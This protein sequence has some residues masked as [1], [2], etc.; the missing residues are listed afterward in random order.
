MSGK[1]ASP[2]DV[3]VVGA[4]MYVCGKGTDGFGTI[5]PALFEAHRQGLVDRIHIAATSRTSAENAQCKAEALMEYMGVRPR[6]LVYPSAVNVDEEAYRLPMA[7]PEVRAAI[8]SVPDRLHF[9]ITRELIGQGLHVQVV[10]P[11]VATVKEVRELVDLAA[12]HQIYGCVEYHKRFDEANLKLLDLIRCGEL[13]RLLNFTIN[14]SQRKVIPTKMF[15]G[16]VESTDIF[17]YLG[18][19][20]VDL[21]YFLT[22]A[23]P[24]RVMSVGLKKYLADQGIDNYDTIHTLVEWRSADGDIFLSSHFTGW[25]DPDTTS[26]MSD[27]RL[28]VVGTNGRYQSDQKHRG[29]TLVTDRGGVEA[30]N[31]YF[32]QFYPGLD[33]DGMTAAGYGPK[34]IVQFLRDVGD[35]LAGRRN[36]ASLAGLRATFASSLVAAAVLEASQ[37]S[38][39]DNNGWIA[40]G[41]I[42]SGE[43]A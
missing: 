14:Y 27:Q 2:F 16:W 28:E 29:V 22:G 7:L 1:T 12:K 3:L 6:V 10:K 23:A 25:V 20:Y 9:A 34:S 31:P 30:I 33:G 24:L 13:G 43:M 4:G 15:R 19:H 17:Q 39:K 40:T 42:L 32:T 5:L 37:R 41:S 11:L 8:V 38:L 18:V 35:I 26:A 21:I 36:A